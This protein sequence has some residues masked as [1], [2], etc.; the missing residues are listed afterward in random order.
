MR[1]FEEDMPGD[2]EA[3]EISDLPVAPL[4]R[5]HRHIAAL[6][7]I[8]SARR[9]VRVRI[10]RVGTIVGAFILL[11]LVLFGSFPNWREAIAQVFVHRV[12]PSITQS[13]RVSSTTLALPPDA[14]FL[15]RGK[16]ELYWRVT[17]P[18]IVPLDRTL[19]PTPTFCQQSGTM[20]NIDVPTFPPGI[21]GFPLWVAGFDGPRAALNHLE[22]ATPPQYGWFQQLTLI[23]PTNFAG[24][25]TLIGG[26]MGNI[27]PLWFSSP[28]YKQRVM[29]IALNPLD[30]TLSNHTIDDQQWSVTPI[31]IYITRAD[32][33]YLQAVWPGGS[34]AVFFAAG[35]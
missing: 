34:W 28:P 12:S 5:Q 17:T 10:W 18:P 13:Y 11:A 22:R 26:T 7:R 9:A 6:S 14:A 27:A 21:G 3:L 35:K 15:F 2:D 33:Y 29:L 4:K 32:C 25:I 31:D 8:L 1:E 23:A 30:G 16:K 24:R 19:E 20:Q